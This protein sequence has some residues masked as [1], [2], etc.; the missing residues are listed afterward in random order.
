MSTFAPPI[1]KPPAPAKA[2]KPGPFAAAARILPVWRRSDRGERET[3]ALQSRALSSAEPTAG[4]SVPDLGHMQGESGQPLDPGA[5]V[6]LETRFGYDF[7]RV[8]VHTDARGAEAARAVR[9]HAYTQG[10]HIVFAGGRYTLGTEEGLRLVGHELAHVVQ[11]SA[12]RVASSGGQ[13]SIVTDPRLEREADV[14]GDRVARGQSVEGLGTI[15]GGATPGVGGRQLSA[16]GGPMQLDADSEEFKRGYEDGLSG[17]E[18]ASGPLNSA[19]L[20][21]YDEGYAKGHYEL[22]QKPASP[23]AANASKQPPSIAGQTSAPLSPATDAVSGIHLEFLAPALPPVEGTVSRFNFKKGP[24]LFAPNLREKSSDAPKVVYYIAYRTDTK[25][26]EYVIGPDSLDLFTSNLDTFKTIGDTA[27]ASPDVIDY[28]VGFGDAVWDQQG[29]TVTQYFQWLGLRDMASFHA[30]LVR[31]GKE[32]RDQDR[33]KQQRDAKA[34]M[35]AKVLPVIN[36]AMMAAAG[37]RLL[38][39]PRAAPVPGGAAPRTG[40]PGPEPQAGA[41]GGAL[42][43]APAIEKPPLVSIPDDLKGLSGAEAASKIGL[44]EPPAGYRWMKTGDGKL[45]PARNPGT[46]ADAPKLNYNPATKQFEPEPAAAPKQ[47][48]VPASNAVAAEF[49]AQAKQALEARDA[50]SDV[51]ER[52]TGA[53]APDGTAT[54]SGWGTDVHTLDPVKKLSARIGQPIAPNP[55]LDAPDYPGSYNLSHAEKQIAVIKPNQPVGVSRV[56]CLDCQQ[57]Y[58]RLANST[59]RPQIVADPAGVRI[60]LPNGPAVSGSTA[61]AAAVAAAAAQANA[62]ENAKESTKENK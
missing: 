42:A 38:A 25:R 33:T 1:K 45:V 48:V 31:I 3:E 44:P 13:A 41:G 58:Q 59:G 40:A 37:A 21:D 9:A 43:K 60:F 53:R 36:A 6:L 18:S 32:I 7:S 14:A 10:E 8:R 17:R 4:P 62:K 12:G 23:A 49:E 27:Y 46:A 51:P 52:K 57:F 29:D 16:L 56:M 39:G 34:T 50:V 28:V 26:N 5:R 61:G 55:A 11:Q 35:A 24:Y 20:V 2:A 54:V 47:A 19:G 30:E 22:T 15:P